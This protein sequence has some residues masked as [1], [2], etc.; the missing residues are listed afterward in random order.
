MTNPLGTVLLLVFPT[1]LFL[2]SFVLRFFLT[3]NLKNEIDELNIDSSQSSGIPGLIRR[4][5]TL[6]FFYE[7]ILISVANGA[8]IM[9]EPSIG[10]EDYG[11]VLLLVGLLL[12]LVGSLNRLFGDLPRL[13]NFTIVMLFGL[14][15][16]EFAFFASTIAVS[17]TSFVAVILFIAGFGL[18]SVL[19][20]ALRKYMRI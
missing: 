16:G 4:E 9:L 1:V 5:F 8:I 17:P 18:G 15:V 12:S 7:S 3:R 13:V 19:G 6:G 11:L 14:F 20:W 2:T 10:L